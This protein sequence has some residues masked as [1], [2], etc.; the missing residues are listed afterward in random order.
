LYRFVREELGTELLT[1][2]KVTSP[3]EEFDKVF[4]AICARTLRDKE[5]LVSSPV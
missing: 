4:T 2:E 1:G 3:G 5:Q